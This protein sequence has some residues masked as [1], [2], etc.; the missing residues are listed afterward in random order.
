MLRI[1]ICDD[2][3]DARLVLRSA[4]ERILD[5]RNVPAQYFEFSSGE[6]LLQWYGRHAGEL[7]LLFL[8]MELREMDGM[9]TA[10]RLRAADEGLQLVFV[11]GYADH[12]FDGYSVGALGYLMKPPRN[13]Q[14]ES[15]LYRAQA[16][17]VRQ[18]DQAYICRSGE[19]YYRIPM[20]KILYFASDRRQVQCVTP[21]RTYIFYGKLDTVAADV[22]S[23]FVRIHQRYLVRAGAV[24]RLESG[25][26]TL[27]DGTRLPVSRS[28][29]QSALLALTRAELEG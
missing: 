21:D 15:V 16:A 12:V 23:R 4:L 14:L 3:A 27:Q 28:C 11:T 9:E 19:T 17:L 29:Q 5:T 10:R 13:E 8:D 2:L 24:A 25:E 1:G 20:G 18:L 6:T 26:V 7:D 22:G